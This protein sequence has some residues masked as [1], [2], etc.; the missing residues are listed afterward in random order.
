M[1]SPSVFQVNAANHSIHMLM[2]PQA[3][4]DIESLIL[5]LLNTS[6]EETIELVQIIENPTMSSGHSRVVPVYAKSPPYKEETTES[7]PVKSLV[8]SNT[9]TIESVNEST[10]DIL[11]SISNNTLDAF[12]QKNPSDDVDITLVFYSWLGLS[13]AWRYRRRMESVIIRYGCVT[14]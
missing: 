7:I 2:T 3:Q 10:P 11:S 9:Q 5:P 14:L 1:D 13:R 4:L 6:V 12:F 8:K